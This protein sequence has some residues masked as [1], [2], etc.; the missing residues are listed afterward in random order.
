MK[1]PN[2]KKNERKAYFE[3]DFVSQSAPSVRKPHHWFLNG[4]ILVYTK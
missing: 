3:R 4:P 2:K 1:I